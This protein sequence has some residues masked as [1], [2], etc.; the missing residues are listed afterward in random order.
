MLCTFFILGAELRRIIAYDVAVAGADD[1][2]GAIDADLD[3]F[4]L[5]GFAIVGRSVAELVLTAEFFGDAFEGG[6]QSA[7]SRF[8]SKHAA[9]GVVG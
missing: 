1:E 3:R 8:G 5:A 9:T 4:A 2:V 6:G 7:G